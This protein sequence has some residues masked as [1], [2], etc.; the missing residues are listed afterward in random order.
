MTCA[1][2]RN[3]PAAASFH[4]RRRRIRSRPP[5]ARTKRPEVFASFFKKKTFLL[6]SSNKATLHLLR[7]Y[8]GA[9]S[10]PNNSQVSVT[11]RL[12]G[13]PERGT[14]AL[15]QHWQRVPG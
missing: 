11:V 3:L 1:A 4:K 9:A 15:H 12:P 10:S 6:P 13:R 7:V 14:R 8:A 2:N 5:T